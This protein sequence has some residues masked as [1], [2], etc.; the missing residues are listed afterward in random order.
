M[1]EM[2]RRL[3]RWLLRAALAALALTLLL[4][5]WFLFLP[6]PL[7]WAFNLAAR[8]AAPVAGGLVV[9]VDAATFRWH[10]GV[11]ELDLTIATPA[12]ITAAGQ[13]FARAEKIRLVFNKA[14]LFGR[15]WLPSRVEVEQPRLSLDFTGEGWPH[16]PFGP[17]PTGAVTPAPGAAPAPA[18]LAALQS[19]LPGP[20]V[21]FA[22]AVNG[23]AAEIH[24]PGG[25]VT[26]NFQP[27]TST[28]V[29]DGDN[30]RLD[31]ALGLAGLKPGA[32]PVTLEARLAGSLAAHTLQ[33]SAH[34]PAFSTEDLPPLPLDAAALPPGK[35]LGLAFDADGTVD[36]E[37]LTLPGLNFHVLAENGELNL[38]AV[39]P[40]G[41]IVLHR[42]EAAVRTTD[43]G[44]HVTADT[45]DLAVDSL[46]LNANNAELVT[47]T[48][49]STL[50]VHRFVLTGP[51][52]NDLVA[53]LPA[54]A[55]NS[56]P[57]PAAALKEIGL[58]RLEAGLNVAV[59]DLSRRPVAIGRLLLAGQLE[60]ALG[61]Q[62][63]P[64]VF[65]VATK[66]PGALPSDRLDVHLELPEVRP[67]A[68]T[69]L[70]VLQ[71]WPV[72]GA[73]DVPL[74]V[75]TELNV[76]ERGEWLGAASS[77]ATTAPGTVHAFGPLLHDV[78]VRN[79]TF[80]AA[81]PDAG[82]TV[83]GGA[84]A[85]D[86]DGPKIALADLNVKRSPTPSAPMAVAGSLTVENVPGGFLADHF[87]RE[88]LAP[89]DQ[90]GV[91][92]SDLRLDQLTG[93][94]TARA[95]PGARPEAASF[96]GRAQARLQDQPL[97]LG[98]DAE[99][100]GPGLTATLDLARV[101]PARF[102]LKLPGDPP[103][104]A[105]DV[106]VQL[107]VRA[108][109]TA[110][111]RLQSVAA[112]LEGGPGFVHANRFFA[113]EIPVTTVSL[114]AAADG[115]MRNL[116][117]DSLALNLDG[118]RVGASQ[119]KLALGD[120]GTPSHVGGMV[121]VEHLTTARVLQWWPADLL[122]A[123][124]AQIAPMLDDG[125]LTRAAFTFAAPFDAAKPAATRPAE[126]KGE[127][128]IA[129][130]RA[131]PPQA[132]GPVTLQSLT[133]NVA[134]PRASV[135]ATGFAAPGLAVPAATVGVAALDQT[136][137]QVEVNA[138]YTAALDQVPAWLAALKLS[139]ATGGALEL[140][141]LTGHGRGHL[142][143]AAPLTFPF[144]P[145]RMRAELSVRVAGLVVPF[146]Q[147]GRALGQG[148]LALTA[149]AANGTYSTRL[150]WKDLQ[151]AVPGLLRGPASLT[152]QTGASVA[153]DEITAQFELN[154]PDVRLFPGGA[155]ATPL[156]APVTGEARFTGWLR[157]P[158]PQIA[159]STR[160][161]NVLGAPLLVAG[162][163][164]VDQAGAKVEHLSVSD[165]KLG[166]TA[167]RAEAG[168]P[169]PGRYE[170]S[171]TGAR[172]DVPGLLALAA[173][174]LP[175]LL[176]QSGGATTPPRSG[177]AGA[178]SPASRI[179]PR[180]EIPTAAPASLTAAVKF[181]EV[182]LGDGL[183]AHD[184]T[185]GAE[186]RDGRPYSASLTGREGA[187]NNLA[188]TLTPA[189]DHQAVALSIGDVPAWLHALTAPLRALALP[190]G[191]LANL[192]A[193]VEKI[194]VILAGGRLEVS[195]DLR[196]AE[197]AKLFEGRFTLRDTTIKQPPVILQLLALRTKQAMQVKPL[198]QELSAGRF[199]LNDT[200]V[201]VEKLTFTAP[202]LLN[203][204]LGSARY[205]LADEKVY[206][207]GEYF[208]I[209]FEV[210]G[211]RTDPQVYLKD[212]LIIRAIGTQSD[213]DFGAPDA[214]KK[215]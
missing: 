30:L 129:H 65:R 62:P 157:Q 106:P 41:P 113:A 82:R 186:L 199:Y 126:L 10:F 154:A 58:T 36:L 91:V 116:A 95:A 67:A 166:G 17:V 47:T 87:S 158:K 159:F 205:G 212:N 23:F 156:L 55:A 131:T 207:E 117:L 211:P 197:P 143:A 93:S 2:P 70:A 51:D 33:F 16:R 118:V 146:T 61:A 64:V 50:D 28:L 115:A 168:N 86:L 188:F 196:P 78:P 101:N 190:P 145:A 167:L 206:A 161:D 189:G 68:F 172:V 32:K 54:A 99:L 35:L 215:P 152:V 150:D 96:K 155:A 162:N 125:E 203:L 11:P 14:A 134:W 191:D 52:G 128:T 127:L 184:L 38:P 187:A 163:A 45:L 80:A 3:R 171:V 85:L 90:F 137:P 136:E 27:I 12:A 140:N 149:T 79:F 29:R 39:K 53:W 56:L 114:D 92:P 88:L 202:G 108:S 153:N 194:P 112:H 20:G 141:R 15:H 210:T 9:R 132:P 42:F 124:R 74:H 21:P 183:A 102:H 66:S 69:R 48:D 177:G 71:P 26:W 103:L 175:S 119:L 60:L 7:G 4:L 59:R 73:L 111:G 123:V 8:R 44:R 120:A 213:L 201:G 109:A 200:A 100:A 89:L 77:V 105:L 147:P 72:V 94:F 104:A 198:V 165:F 31:L 37:H 25:T 176:A 34:V 185:L 142:Q 18:G 63:L 160:S 209:G 214:P 81:T 46:H 181:A 173:P 13:P 1:A 5:G 83:Q 193:Q 97:D 139:P 107:H 121:T 40:G 84:L 148:D 22:L 174:F 208:G 135:T 182:T 57:F 195:G 19:L 49:G 204:N 169:G 138:D 144:D 43:N 170:V 151:V 164:T 180:K 75:T 179:P 133:V 178:E 130:L 6:V 24:A 110:E 76:S 192:A 98:V 122:P